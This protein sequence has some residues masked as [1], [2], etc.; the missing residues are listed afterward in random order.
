MKSGFGNADDVNSVQNFRIMFWNLN[1]FVDMLKCNEVSTW[2]SNACDICFLTETH[3]IKGQN[4]RLKNFN[5]VNH[6]FSEAGEKP[7]GGMCCLIK[8]RCMQ[9]V[10]DVNKDIPDF[11]YIKLRGGHTIFSSYIPPAESIYYKDEQFMNFPTPVSIAQIL[12]FFPQ[13]PAD[14]RVFREI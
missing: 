6:P 7:R 8:E 1:G 12:H 4:F 11:M 9:H 10:I 3:L 13:V 14:F 2:L 5:C